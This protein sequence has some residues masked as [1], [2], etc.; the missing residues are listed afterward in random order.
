MADA[1][2]DY[3]EQMLKMVVYASG[4]AVT[5]RTIGLGV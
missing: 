5:V 2:K 4:E 1:P 3:L